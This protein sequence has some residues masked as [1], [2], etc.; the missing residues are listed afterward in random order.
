M[1]RIQFDR[2]PEFTVALIKPDA[3]DKSKA[4]FQMIQ[5]NGFEIAAHSTKKLTE[6]EARIFY[7]GQ[8]DSPNFE[9]MVKHLSSGPVIALFLKK[10]NAIVDW[11]CLI[12][13]SDPAKAAEGTIRKVF[14]KTIVKNAVHGSSSKADMLNEAY[15]SARWKIFFL[16]TRSCC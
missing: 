9:E 5:K 4:I 6:E 8:R 13:D 15:L 14:G 10:R 2:P 1:I 16:S 11:I 3:V 7:H 12:G